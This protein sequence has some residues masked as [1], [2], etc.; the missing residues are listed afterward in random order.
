MRIGIVLSINEPELAWNAMRFG[1]TALQRGHR[2]RIF[3]LARGVELEGL[4]SPR[5]DVKG[6]LAKYRKRGGEI[7]AC[8]T[9]LELRAK[10]GTEACPASTMQDL[11]A[12]V[13]DFDRVLTF[14]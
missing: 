7:L 10:D 5:F 8:G 12:L 3:L 4:T 9:C 1:V 6:Q 2:V 11:L 14:G 13:E